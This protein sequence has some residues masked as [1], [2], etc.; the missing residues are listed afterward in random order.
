MATYMKDEDEMIQMKN[1][2]TVNN[3]VHTEPQR[4]NKQSDKPH[5]STVQKQIG[6]QHNRTNNHSQIYHAI[7]LVMPRYRAGHAT[8]FKYLH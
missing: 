4:E 8:Q 5:N 6:F 3:T 2:Y 1:T 7:K